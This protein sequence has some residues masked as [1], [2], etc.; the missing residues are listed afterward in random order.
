MTTM[1]DLEKLALSLPHTTRDESDDGRPSYLVHRN[2]FF[3]HRARRRDAVDSQTG[4]RLDDVLMFR[5]AD[6]GVKELLLADDRGVFFTT[7]HFDGYPAVLMRIPDLAR[8]E[9]EELQDMVVEAW[10]TRA[11]KRVAR[12]WLQEH[13]VPDD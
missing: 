2:L 12:A 11:Q 6:L 7:P 9:R 5:V 8:L 13:G 1:R 4:E 3:C 10:L